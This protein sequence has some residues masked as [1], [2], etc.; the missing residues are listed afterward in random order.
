MIDANINHVQTNLDFTSQQKYNRYRGAVPTTMQAAETP[1]GARGVGGLDSPVSKI[2]SLP[3]QCD[4]R[5]TGWFGSYSRWSITITSTS[6]IIIIII[7][8]TS[9]SPPASP[10]AQGHHH[11]HHHHHHSSWSFDTSAMSF[12]RLRCMSIV[13]N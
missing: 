9:A 11:H 2:S 6:I 7:T 4:M 13:V 10:P 8:T 5:Q 1:L 3:R 12:P